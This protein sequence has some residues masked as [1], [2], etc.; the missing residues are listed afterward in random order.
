MPEGIRLS[1]FKYSHATDVRRDLDIPYVV[2][3]SS[4]RELISVTKSAFIALAAN[5]LELYLLAMSC[6]EYNKIVLI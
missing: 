5:R 4:V 2:S 1:R 3:F 6:T